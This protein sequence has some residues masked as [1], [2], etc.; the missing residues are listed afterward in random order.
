MDFVHAVNNKSFYAILCLEFQSIYYERTVLYLNYLS[1]ILSF[2][3]LWT[4]F[5]TES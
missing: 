2:S 1:S 5:N 3:I 4:F